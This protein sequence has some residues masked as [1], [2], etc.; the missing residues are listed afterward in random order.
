MP[1]YEYVCEKCGH[2]FEELV[3]QEDEKPSCPK[4]GEAG[5]KRIISVSRGS[6]GS[7]GGTGISQGLPSASSCGGGGGFS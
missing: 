5:C 7:K 2:E 3:F 1:I 6:A 4:C